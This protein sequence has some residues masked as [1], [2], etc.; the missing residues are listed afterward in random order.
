[1][2]LIDVSVLHIVQSCFSLGEEHDLVAL[3]PSPGRDAGVLVSRFRAGQGQK[4]RVVGEI[5]A[6]IRGCLFHIIYFLSPL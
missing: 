3:S 6:K 2:S 5:P 4:H 1:M